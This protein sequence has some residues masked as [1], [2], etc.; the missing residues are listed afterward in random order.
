[1]SKIPRIKVTYTR[2]SG[3]WKEIGGQK[4]FF[5]SRWEA[6]YAGYLQ[7]QKEKGLIQ[8]WEYEPKTFWF[9]GIKRGVCSYK[10]DFRVLNAQ[11]E[12]IWYE[13]KGF[14]DARSKTKLKRFKSYFP[15][16]KLVV[17]DSKW[18]SAVTRLC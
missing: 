2:S 7:W 16:E 12:S 13:V 18:F 3:F 4:C 6:I 9:E 5:R 15:N 17:I 11:G 10:P 14:M 1:V 8:S